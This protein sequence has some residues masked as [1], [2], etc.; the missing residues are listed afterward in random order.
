LGTSLPAR[1][2]LLKDIPDIERIVLRASD[3]APVYLRDVAEVVIGGE[4]RQGQ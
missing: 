4:V 1:G 2:R 3:G